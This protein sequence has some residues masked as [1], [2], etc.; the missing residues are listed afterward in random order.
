[1]VA[2][3]GLSHLSALGD[4]SSSKLSA[5]L[6]G[7]AAQGPLQVCLLYVFPAVSSNS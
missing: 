5:W 3:F 4:K 6:T 1:V 2:D 7:G